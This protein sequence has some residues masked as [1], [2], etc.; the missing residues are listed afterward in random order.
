MNKNSLKTFAIDARRELR[1]KIEN[2]L[3]ILGITRDKIEKV[4]DLGNQIENNGNIYSKKGYDDLIEKYSI[5]GFEQLLEESAYTWFNRLVALAYMEINNYIEDKMVFN[6]DKYYPAILDEYYKAEF[7]EQLSFE[8]KEEIETLKDRGTKE[9]LEKLY[10]ILVE[11]KCKELSKIM[12]FMFSDEAEEYK[13]LVFPKNLL[14]ENSFLG[15]LRKEINDAKDE[16][17]IVPIELI[18]WLYQFYNSE[19]K[20]EVFEGLKKNQKITKENIPAATQLFTPDWIVKYMVENSLGRLANENFE[21]RKEIKNNWKYYIES[22]KI[23]SSEKIKIEDIKIIDPA[24]GSGHMLTYAFDL[25]FEI[26][27]ELGW[28]KKEAVLSILKNNLYGLEIDERAAQLASFAILMKAREKFPRIFRSLETLEEDEKFVLNTIS[29]EESN[30][31]SEETKKLLKANLLNL[32][33][34]FEDAKEY[35]SILKIENLDIERLKEELREVKEKFKSKQKLS[36]F[37]EEENFN[38]I[39]RLIKQYEIMKAKYDVTIT[40]PP[41]MGGKGFSPKLKTYVE[42]NYKDTKSDLFAVFIERCNEFTKKN[43]YTSMITMQSWMFLTS[44]ETLR[45]KLIEETEIQSLNHLGA[46]AFSEI[47]GEVVQTVAW[48]SKNKNPEIKGEYIRLVDYNN[49][50][51]KEEEYFNKK[52]RFQANQKDFEKIPGSPIAYW[53]SK[54]MLKTFTEGIILKDLGILREG[55]KTGNNELYIYYWT[56]I[57]YKDFYKKDKKYNKK[58]FPHHKGGEFRKWYGNNLEVIFWENDGEK[59]KSLKNSGISGKE[60]YFKPIL[61][62]SKTSS[63]HFGIRIYRDQ[64]FD[65][66]SPAIMLYDTAILE[67]VLAFLTSLGEKYLTFINPSLSTQVGDIG[68][69]PLLTTKNLEIVANIKKLV[70]QNIDISKE[71]WD[72]RETSWDFKGLALLNAPTLKEAYKN[73]CSYWTEQ[74]IQMHKNEEELNKIFIEIYEL[75]D[76][77]DEK[78]AFED[79]TLL[80]KEANI[81]Y[82]QNSP[83][84]YLKERGVDLVFNKE[85]LIKQFL[86][87]AVG[88]IMGRYSID[89]EGLIIANS[90]DKLELSENKFIVRGEEGIR[91]EILNPRF[92]PEEF[93]IISFTEE[94]VFENDIVKKVIDFLKAAYGEENLSENL[95]FIA[96]ALGGKENDSPKEIL[97]AYFIKDFYKDHL[98]RYQK[99]PIYWL[100]N[101]GNKN[102]FSSL[103]YLHRYEPNTVARVRTD[104]LLEYQE[105]MIKQKEYYERELT[106]ENL[107]PRDKKQ[108]E[109]RLKELDNILKEL[110]DY[111]NAVKHIAEQKIALDLDD[112]VKVNYEKLGSVLRG[113]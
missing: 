86:S 24:M 77:M 33:S 85:E 28:S 16:K 113:I 36:L 63:S 51:L 94:E 40:N 91:H 74:F 109:K 26:Y 15:K 52:N 89:K 62:W 42:K 82:N 75:Q 72:S 100:M 17:N 99:R 20:D 11:E 59:I 104:Y 81:E 56:E 10:V 98:Q 29:I 90:D 27:E 112:G 64:L 78:V 44:F 92:S 95:D 73:Y 49:A 19:K 32:L 76:E 7:F 93:G 111:A 106:D 23:E 30:S 47:D 4:T 31:I 38:K 60:M 70:Q 6:T 97:R 110:K 5:L 14:S 102:A 35:G 13:K 2:K 34:N 53:V 83:Y 80:K 68:I 25:L 101:S 88:C 108:A 50:D 61:S 48:I 43:C 1:E 22:E 57:C 96:K 87:Y 21:I 9:D 84:E 3:N 67:Y 66:A 69:I 79:I 58:W 8:R 103:I 45:T 107:S 37:N 12:P 46:R 71:E 65:S 39:E 54:K 41:Y 105:K 55:V 18:G